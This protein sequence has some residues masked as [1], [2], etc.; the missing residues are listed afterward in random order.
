MSEVFHTKFTI[1][2]LSRIS[3]HL[4]SI[5]NGVLILLIY[6]DGSKRYN[7]TIIDLYDRSVVAGISDRN[8]T[9]DLAKRTLQKSIDS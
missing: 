3:I 7:C 5:E 8:I 6:S 1:I 9:S 2:N 4:R